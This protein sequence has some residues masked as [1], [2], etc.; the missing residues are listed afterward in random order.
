[1]TEAITETSLARVIWLFIL[2]LFG[3]CTKLDL[4]PR[5]L[6]TSVPVKELLSAPE[7]VVIDGRRYVLKAHLYQNLMPGWPRGIL[8]VIKV[9]ALNS[10]AFPSS[11][12]AD[13]VWIIG[14]QIW[15]CKLLPTNKP[16]PS[17][18]ILEKRVGDSPYCPKGYVEV[19]VR[20]VDGSGRSHLLRA[21]RQRIW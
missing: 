20:L 16:S 14:P 13:H 8:A 9:I 12:D 2:L 1:M 18:N 5:I 6:P 19:I 17:E 15:E 10:T 4:T 21:S 11:V 3:G 7:E